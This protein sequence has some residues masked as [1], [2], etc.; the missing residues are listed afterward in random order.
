VKT[1]VARFSVCTGV[2]KPH[3]GAAFDGDKPAA[4]K[5]IQDT[6]VSRVK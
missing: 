5:T 6:I 4:D 1:I 3:F 2:S